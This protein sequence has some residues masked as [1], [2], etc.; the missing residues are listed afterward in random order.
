MSSPNHATSNIKDAFSSN[1][2]DFI[3]ASPDYVP[4]LLGK[5]YSSSPNSFG[6]VPIASPSLF[7]FHNDPYMK[8]LQAFYAKESPIPPPNPITPLVIL[9]SSPVLPP[10]PL[11]DPQY[12]F[13][14]EELLP[15]KKQIHP[16][17]SSSTTLSNHLRSKH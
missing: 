12:F 7:L 11:F 14:S 17:S 16:P 15:P 3:P 6:I 9:T 1:I 10:S 5:T 13:V 2:L 4:T 8:V